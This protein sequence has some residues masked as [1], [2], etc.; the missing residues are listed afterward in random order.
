MF[1]TT[2]KAFTIEFGQALDKESACALVSAN[3][4]K[5]PK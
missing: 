5:V 4:N 3:K 1:F 2:N